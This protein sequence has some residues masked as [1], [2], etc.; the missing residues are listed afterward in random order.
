MCIRDRQIRTEYNANYIIQGSVQSFGNNRRLTLELNDLSK[1]SVVWSKKVD[2]K[3]DDI[4][5]VQDNIGMQILEE[6]QV[7][8]VVGQQAATWFEEFGFKTFEQ[9]TLFLNIRREGRKGTIIPLSSLHDSKV[10]WKLLT[11]GSVSV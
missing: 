7:K 10:A 8:A 11:V 4:F 3:L 6:L 9:Y 1:N 5:K 2:F